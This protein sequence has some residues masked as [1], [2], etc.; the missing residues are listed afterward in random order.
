MR[1]RFRGLRSS[2]PGIEIALFIATLLYYHWLK[3]FGPLTTMT[4]PVSSS[5][6][7]AASCE[8]GLGIAFISGLADTPV[9]DTANNAPSN[10]TNHCSLP[11]TETS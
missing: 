6:K 4:R 5:V 2:I 10:Q 8:L 1:S 3:A 9:T 11:H 7:N